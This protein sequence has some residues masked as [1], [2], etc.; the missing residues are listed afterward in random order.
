MP[1]DPECVRNS[2]TYLAGLFLSSVRPFSAW[3]VCVVVFQSSLGRICAY[4]R[5][6]C[7]MLACSSCLKYACYWTDS[8]PEANL[9]KKKNDWRNEQTE[10]TLCECV[11]FLCDCM[12]CGLVHNLCLILY[13]PNAL[14][15]AVV[16]FCS[17]SFCYRRLRGSFQA[18]G[19]KRGRT[20]GWIRL[21][22]T[23]PSFLIIRAD[24]PR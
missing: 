14:V 13:I 11:H 20:M 24:P 2:I 10:P 12:H 22:K 6:L 15:V 23:I 8:V 4:R 19:N 16:R 17:G 7:G 9:I 5:G 21:L 1:G 3:H 18:T